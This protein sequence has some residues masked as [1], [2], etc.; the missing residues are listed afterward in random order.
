MNRV[1][2]NTPPIPPAEVVSEV[3]NT[4]SRMMPATPASMIQT[5]DPNIRNGELANK[6][7]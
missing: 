3:A 4:F 7:V 5:L 1:G 2:A 6:D